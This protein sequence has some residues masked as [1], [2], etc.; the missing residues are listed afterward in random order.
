[1][2]RFDMKNV[3]LNKVSYTNSL[4]RPEIIMMWYKPEKLIQN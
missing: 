4:D 1:M 2:I 3:N